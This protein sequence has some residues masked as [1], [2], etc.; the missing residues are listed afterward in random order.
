MATRPS[1]TF[2]SVTRC[3]SSNWR[4]EDVAFVHLSLNDFLAEQPSSRPNGNGTVMLPHK[5]WQFTFCAEIELYP[6]FDKKKERHEYDKSPD[7]YCP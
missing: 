5:R 2:M 6:A 7:I 3:S 1:L 4:V